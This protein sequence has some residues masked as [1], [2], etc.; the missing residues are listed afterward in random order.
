[1]GTR[2]AVLGA[3][4]EVAEALSPTVT[5]SLRLMSLHRKRIAED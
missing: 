2:C 4:I 5:L 3:A 1:M